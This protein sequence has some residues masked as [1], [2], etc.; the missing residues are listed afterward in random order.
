[1]PAVRRNLQLPLVLGSALVLLGPHA[2]ESSQTTGTRSGSPEWQKGITFTHEYSHDSNLLSRRSRNSLYY[3]RNRLNAEWIALNPFGYQ[4]RFNSPNIYLEADPPDQHLIHAIRDAHQLG[5]KVMLKPHI[6]LRDRSQQKWRGA[7]E[8]EDESQWRAWFADYEAF[9][10]HYARIAATEG[11]EMLCI[12]TELTLTATT[13]ARAW[14]AVIA[15]VRKIY[16]GPLVYAANWW[17]EYDRIQFWSE[18]DYIG[19][20]AFFPLSE[21]PSPSLGQLKASA[22]AVADS[23]EALSWRTRKPV[24]FTEVGFKSVKGTSVSPWKWTRR[25]EAVDLEEQERCYRAVFEVFW[26]RPWFYGMYW[27]KWYS[28]LNRGGPDH[29]GFTPR[30]KP[31]EA[32]VANWYGKPIPRSQPALR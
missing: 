22:S 21:T 16:D 1:M 15:K 4:H 24:I 7:I 31:A 11:V 29:P 9:I 3:L 30:R 5:L 17:A 14:R 25:H 26:K 28:D 8:M 12:G 32:I 20:N 13:R 2:P 19:I 10:L 23:I 6:W 18:L 27:W